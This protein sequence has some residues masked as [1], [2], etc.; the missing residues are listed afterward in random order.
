M[1]PDPKRLAP[2]KALIDSRFAEPLD[3]LTLARTA[4]LSRA[5]FSR[6]FHRTF[7]LPPRQYLIA[8]RMERAAAL[9]RT[10]DAS[11][12]EV[13]RQVGLTSIGSF[14]TRFSRTYG[15]A[16]TDYRAAHRRSG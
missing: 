14:T 9:L 6:E 5:H 13:C 8:R 12:T 15:V 2:A 11:V 10:G 3:V 4:R 16:P 1:P 7:G